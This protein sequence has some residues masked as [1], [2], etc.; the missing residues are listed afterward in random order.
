[1]PVRK[2]TRAAQGSGSIRQRPDGKWE[3]RY[4]PGRD[5]G[6]GNQ[7]QKSVYGATQREVVDK[8]AAIKAGMNSGTY[9]EPSKLTVG[10]WLDIWAAEYLGGVK[11]HTVKSYETAC[12]VHLKPALGAVRLQ[13]LSAHTIQAAYNQLQRVKELSPKTIKNIHGVLHRALQQAMELGYIKNNPSE[14]CITP[15]IEKRE[16][17]ILPDETIPAFLNAIKGHKYGTV[18]FV[19]LFTGLRQGE[20]LGLTWDAIDFD[21]GTILINKQLQKEH[22]KGGE[23]RLVSTKRDRVRKITPALAVM[24]CLRQ[25]RGKQA[26]MR[27]LAGAEWS[28]PLELVFTHEFGGNFAPFTVYKHLKRIVASIGVPAARFHDL[29]HSYAVAALQSGD[30]VKTVQEN[31]GH[32]TAAFTL[33]VYGHVTERMRKESAARMDA[34]IHSVQS[35]G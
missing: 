34:F 26:E 25:H 1:M 28:N 33:D 16:M 13:T 32:H 6:T 19:D 22:K 21:R 18:Y 2:N 23:Y 12:R 24:Q 27:L 30:D 15:R 31:L 10:Q 3:G 8:L 5:P 4:T 29:R 9:T 14:A 35:G 7:I 11:P 20:I 17:V